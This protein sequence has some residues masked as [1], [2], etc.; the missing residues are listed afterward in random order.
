MSLS[1]RTPVQIPMPKPKWVRSHVRPCDNTVVV[2]QRFAPALL[3]AFALMPFGCHAQQPAP[4]TAA[5][6]AAPAGSSTGAPLSPELARRVEVALRQ[7]ANLPPESTVNV[8]GR[9]SSEFPGYDAVTVTVVNEG[10]TSR[11]ILFLLSRDG[12]T[13]AQLSKFDISADPKMLVS[14][15]GR[16]ARGGPEGAPVEIVGFDDLECPFCA[17]L[18]ATVFPALTERYG[19]KVRFVY[20]DYPLEEI[21]PWALRA[22]VD[23]NC[24]GSQSAPAYWSA[25]DYVHAHAGEIGAD[26]KDSKAE[27]TLARASEQLDTITRDQAQGRKIDMAQLNSCLAKQDATAINASREQASRL[28]LA[29]TP[30]LYIN[31][32]KI[33]GAVSPAFLFG[34]IDQALKVA[35]VQPPPPYV[36]PGAAPG[37]AGTG[38]APV[39]R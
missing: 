14:G 37:A 4:G 17:R 39:G 5:P 25:V 18:H 38:A 7:K 29:S 31:G 6:V 36:A 13:L 26:P 22:A 9:T 2:F 12:K 24:L 27:K 23:V 3:F 1:I 16:P 15:G 10:R 32:D 8:G 19:N 28:E 35:G 11:P 30:V 21:H 20:K 33:D 34:I